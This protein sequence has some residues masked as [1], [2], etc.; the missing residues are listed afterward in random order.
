MRTSLPMLALVLLS[1]YASAAEAQDNLDDVSLEVIGH[2]DPRRDAVVLGRSA[3]GL[4][5]VY[6]PEGRIVFDDKPVE[7]WEFMATGTGV[8]GLTVNFPDEMVVQVNHSAAIDEGRKLRALGRLHVDLE[9]RPF[10]NAGQFRMEHDLRKSVITALAETSEGPVKVEIRAHVPDDVIRIDIHDGRRTPGALTIRLEEDA[11]AAV[12]SDETCG[13]CLWHENPADAVAPDKP[14]N[15]GTGGDI[16]G[17]NKGW[18]AGRV[19][20]LA[21]QSENE[22]CAISDRTLTFPARARHGLLIVGVS[23]LGG[24]DRF[25]REARERQNKADRE[26]GEAFLRKHEAWWND[27]WQRSRLV[28]HDPTGQMLKYQTAF[29]LYRYYLACCAGQRRETPPRF[30]IDLYRYHLRQHDWLTGIICA[31]EQYQSYYGAMRTGDWDALRG[32]AS[33]YAAKLPYY[34]HFARR[35]YGHGGARIPMWQGAAVLAPPAGAGPEQS[36]VGIQ[37]QPYNGENPAGQI[38][39]LSL[40]CDY[41]SITGDRDFARDVLSPLAADLVEFV[42][43]RYPQREQGRMV[44]AP[45]NAGETWQ[46]VRDPSEMVCALR[47]ALPRLITVGRT[48]GWKK[49]LVDQWEQLLAS[50]PEVPLGKFRYQGAEVKPEILPGD[51]LVPAADMSSCEAYKLPWSGDK[52]HYQLNAQQTELYAIWPAKLVLRDNAQRDCAIRSY[53]DR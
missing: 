38:W 1:G 37:Q 30:Q 19:F 43:L 4:S 31:V 47:D 32:L 34:G 46:G 24:Q 2:E 21:L 27:F 53:R 3:S 28:I 22:S 13:V 41:V 18:L 44:I 8:T 26:G 51:Q 15:S 14:E 29:D 50:V 40:F 6:Y 49:E 35:A 5:G 45:C 23:T 42:R 7:E 9:G 10:A 20:G 39:M 12:N 16:P 11:S 25:V 33:F 36:P 52:L 17:D 48:Q